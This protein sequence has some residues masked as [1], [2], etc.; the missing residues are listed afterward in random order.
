MAV[1]SA[2]LTDITPEPQRAARFGQMGAAAGIG[3]IAGPVLGG[4]LGE[5]LLRAPFLLAAALN[6]VSL[7]LGWLVLPDSRSPGSP[8]PVKASLNAFSALHRLRGR[9]RLLPLVGVFGIVAFVGQWPSTLWILY[10]QDRFGWSTWLAGLSLAGYGLCHALA[11]ALAIAPL[12]ARL[13]ERRALLLGLACD[14][15]GLSLLAVAASGWVPFALLPLFAGGGMALPALQAMV[16]REVDDAHQGELQGTLASITSLIGVA[17]PLIVTA[18]YA[19]S[20]DLWPGL[21]W[22]VG[23][24]VYLLA[25][26]LLFK[27]R[28]SGGGPTLGTSAAK[29]VEP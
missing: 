11:Q 6:G 1:A 5:W 4:L 18:L 23:A 16:T 17:G 7:L 14:A 29:A 13:G 24:A 15:V 22:A 2:Y 20:R 25:L 12:V 19:A 21:V 10:G 3:F 9:P 8:R 27:R 28:A 26:P